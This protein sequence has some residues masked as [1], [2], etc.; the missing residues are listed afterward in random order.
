MADIVCIPSRGRP[1]PSPTALHLV[2]GGVPYR[3][4]VRHDEYNLYRKVY[5]R[6]DLV[7]L[8][9]GTEGIAPTKQFILDWAIINKCRVIMADDDLKFFVRIPTGEKFIQAGPEDLE[10]LCRG[11]FEAL[12]DYTA[13]GIPGRF[14]ANN[15]P[16]GFVDAKRLAC[17]WA[18]DP[19]KVKKA[20]VKYGAVP[21]QVDL[22]FGLELLLRGHNVGLY[23]EAAHD[24]A[25]GFGATG[26]CSTFR[27]AKV[28]ADAS[29]KM[30]EMYPQYVKT[31]VR[32]SSTFKSASENGE[33]LEVRVQWS[34][35][36]KDGV[37]NA[38]H[39]SP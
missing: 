28:L 39:Q 20:G 29:R 5:D 14:L 4:F 23:C 13:I 26:G 7:S 8:P 36:Y 1:K 21:V 38:R 19:V 2:R 18:V 27:T 22:L 6:N 17:F 16:R 37:N 10:I 34:K 30:E 11:L 31:F 33:R 12:D 35:A 15:L 25:S 24:Q 32:K 3:I 9:R